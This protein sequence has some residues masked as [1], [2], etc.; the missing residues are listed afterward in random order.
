ME[1]A[2]PALPDV[3]IRDWPW[4][5]TNALIVFVA[6]TFTAAVA[7]TPL[8]ERPGTLV[9]PLTLSV[10]VMAFAWIPHVTV[11]STT[12]HIRTLSRTTEVELT[13]LIGIDSVTNP[14]L[15]QRIPRLVMLDGSSTM[16]PGR[17][18]SWSGM[19][20]ANQRAEAAIRARAAAA[21][22]DLAGPET[23]NE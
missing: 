18:I 11:T 7:E 8:F 21:G 14:L 16:L 5:V 3:T 10:V 4:I 15:R 9:L 22:N 2:A 6:W 23:S 19:T 13:D 17:G 1:H 12:V 20:T